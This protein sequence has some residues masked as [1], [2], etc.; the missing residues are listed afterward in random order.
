MVSI[1]AAPEDVGM[2]AQ[3]LERIAPALQRYVDAGTYGGF[4]A[5]VMR[6]G[7]LVHAARVGWQDREAAVPMADD[8]IFRIYS[9]T[10]P[11]ICTALMLL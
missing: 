2:N 3:R 1:N 6:R 11:I 8:T 4:H 10:K 9:M 7:R 5:L